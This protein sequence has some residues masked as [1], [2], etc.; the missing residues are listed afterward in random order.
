MVSHAFQRFVPTQVSLELSFLKR[1]NAIERYLEELLHE[2]YIDFEL[3]SHVVRCKTRFRTGYLDQ[4]VEVRLLIKV[5]YN[6]THFKATYSLARL[7][8]PRQKYA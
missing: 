5:P 7:L 6:T 3:C 2:D 8:P 1:I 4:L